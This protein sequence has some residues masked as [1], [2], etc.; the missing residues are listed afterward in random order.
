MRSG[1]LIAGLGAVGL[2]GT[3]WL[4]LPSQPNGEGAD[5][6]A[7]APEAHAAAPLQTNCSDLAGFAAFRDSLGSAIHDRDADGLVAISHPGIELG[8][9]GRSGI[10][11]MR[12]WLDDDAELWSELG[13]LADAPCAMAGRE[14]VVI[15][16]DG[17]GFRL[18]V[19]RGPT[20]W[21]IDRLSPDQPSAASTS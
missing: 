13:A 8:A 20:G 7:F 16:P 3:M 5:A 11:E 4:A 10:D 19:E 15:D 12:R 2:A 18:T 21:R 9:D 1:A 14:Q 17:H 6:L